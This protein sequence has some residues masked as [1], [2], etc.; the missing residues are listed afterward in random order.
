[1]IN[2]LAF[3]ETLHGL[4]QVSGFSYPSSNE[5]SLQEAREVLLKSLLTSEKKV[6]VFDEVDYT[7]IYNGFSA[8]WKKFLSDSHQITKS[9]NHKNIPKITKLEIRNLDKITSLQ[10]LKHFTKL[11][12]LEVGETI[13]D[14]SILPELK[15]LKKIKLR[16][17]NVKDLVVLNS[18]A[19]LEEIVL[20][21]IQGFESD[22]DCSGLLNES[23]AK[24]ELDFSGIK[25]ERFPTA[26]TTFKSLTSLSMRDCNFT[27]IPESIGNL[28]RLTDLN[29]DSNKLS[30]L[31]A[32]IGKLEQLTELYLDSNQFSIFPD[33]VLSLKNLQL[34]WIRWNQIVS[35]P[36]GIGQ[37]SSL[38]D[39][40]LHENQLSDVPSA[41]SKMAQLAELNLRKNKLTKFPEAVTLIKNL[42]ILDLSENQ[43]TSIPDSIGNL[44]TLEVLDLE[45]LPINSL[46]AQL[47]KLE[48]LISLR[49]QKTKLVDVPDFLASMKSLKNI[50]FES[51]E[52]NRL[53]QWCEFEYNKYKT[54][55]HSKK[56]PEAATMIK[57][58]FSEKGADFLKLNQWEVKLKISEGSYRKAETFA[59][60]V[61]ALA[62][63][64]KDEE[65]FSIASRMTGDPYNP[66]FPFSQACYFAR[67]G[68]KEPML[69]AIR[70]AVEL[71]AKT[72]QFVSEYD[73]TS[74][75]KDPDFLEAIVP[76]S[77]DKK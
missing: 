73:F 51:E 32:G 29:L 35:L 61:Y 53:K 60:V 11:E 33:A 56:F 45:G 14:A 1:E 66:R 4:I 34:L 30:A 8:A 28:K 71:G 25:F 9:K 2:P 31:P 18:C 15:N 16:S 65:I 76:K 7:E 62:T 64:L 58:L 12:E 21:N 68:Q 43:I 55:L 48:A 74:F 39:L 77:E 75:K 49:L 19:G 46:P 6:E 23:K 24:I 63:I 40:S 36:D 20:R 38:K 13:K 67:T 54:R 47:E 59:T 41:I 17:W 26:A 22:F 57:S 37:M 52:Y 44:G 70:K 27:E 42:R 5:N 50:Y 3:S 72:N 10:E 69:Q